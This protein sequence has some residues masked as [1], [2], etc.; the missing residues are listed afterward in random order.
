MWRMCEWYL[1]LGNRSGIASRQGTCGAR[2]PYASRPNPDTEPGHLEA[3]SPTRSRVS[4]TSRLIVDQRGATTGARPRGGKA[5]SRCGA[6]SR[7]PLR[8]R[9][10]MAEAQDH[11]PPSPPRLAPECTLA[12]FFRLSGPLCRAFDAPGRVV[13]RRRAPPE[14]AWRVERA[15]WR[16]GIAPPTFRA[17]FADPVP[18]VLRLGAVFA[19][20]I[21]DRIRVR[22]DPA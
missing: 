22:H 21:F 12:G 1:T 10:A 2:Q 15:V 7:P 19:E 6:A 18:D 17:G 16:A 14:P 4:G 5:A 20:P 8:P 13:D 9:L 11:G 3:N